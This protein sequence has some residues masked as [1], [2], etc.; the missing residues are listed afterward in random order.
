MN[1]KFFRNSR[2]EIINFKKMIPENIRHIFRLSYPAVSGIAMK[3]GID[4]TKNTNP[5]S[6]GITI[7][8][9][10]RR[11]VSY[12]TSERGI[13]PMMTNAKNRRCPA[14]TILVSLD[15]FKEF[16]GE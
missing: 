4:L 2:S 9:S 13:T 6:S 8:K 16:L 5:S 3:R 14:K 7:R 11:P 15:L 12:G 1:F 10:A